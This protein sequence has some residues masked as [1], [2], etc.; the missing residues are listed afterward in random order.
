[1]SPPATGGSK[2]E[3]W[4]SNPRAGR[5]A[6]GFQDRRLR[7]L[8]HPPGGTLPAEMPEVA[9]LTEPKLPPSCRQAMRAPRGAPRSAAAALGRRDRDAR[10]GC[11]NDLLHPRT[12]SRHRNESRDQ[13]EGGDRARSPDQGPGASWKLRSGRDDDQ[14]DHGNRDEGC[15]ERPPRPTRQ[16]EG[17]MSILARPR[18]PAEAG[19]RGAR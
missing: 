5:P 4:D 1:M 16:I 6:N 18:T 3:G 9:M 13:Q 7:P 17:H 2:R 12:K 10:F 8:G 15:Q 11:S 19:R 14:E